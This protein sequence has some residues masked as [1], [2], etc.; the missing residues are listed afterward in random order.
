MRL[1]DDSLLFL[2]GKMTINNVPCDFVKLNV[3]TNTWTNLG[4]AGEIHLG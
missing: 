3:L 4:V 2:C 1:V